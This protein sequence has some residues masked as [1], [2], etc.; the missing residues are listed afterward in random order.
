MIDLDQ[1]TI[2]FQIKEHF[3]GVAFVGVDP[4]Q[5]WYPAISLRASQECKF[6]FGSDFSPFTT[7][8]GYFPVEAFFL[9]PKMD[10]A[11]EDHFAEDVESV[12]EVAEPSPPLPPLPTPV[13]AN[14]VPVTQSAEEKGDGENKQAKPSSPTA[15]DFLTSN[16]PWTEE[17]EKWVSKLPKDITL[18]TGDE[19]KDEVEEKDEG[20]EQEKDEGRVNLEDDLPTLEEIDAEIDFRVAAQVYGKRRVIVFEDPEDDE[21]GDEE[22]Q[23]PQTPTLPRRPGLVTALSTMMDSFSAQAL[24]R[25]FEPLVDRDEVPFFGPDSEEPLP[26]L[27]FEITVGSKVG[28]PST[29]PQECGQFGLTDSF[30]STWVMMVERGSSLFALGVI[31]QGTLEPRYSV[32]FDSAASD[33]PPGQFVRP[34]TT[35]GCGVS[36]TRNILFFTRNGKPFGPVFTDIP[37]PPFLPITLNLTRYAINYGQLDFLFKSANNSQ[38]R[39]HLRLAMNV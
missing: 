4:T 37:P 25:K 31:R 5:T 14:P 27:Y 13:L 38:L 28:T 36:L 3:L 34:F 20:E 32:F 26:T 21:D 16:I 30:G 29:T 6:Y 2:S 12:A 39:D 15:Q 33:G 1:G 24:W 8:R 10:Q 23:L 7:P 19:E 35:F 9:P 22:D 11:D 17:F 18:V